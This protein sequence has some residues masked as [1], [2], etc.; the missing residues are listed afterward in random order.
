VQTSERSEA[1]EFTHARL[2]CDGYFFICLL[3]VQTSERSG[4][5]EFTHARLL[6]DGYFFI[7]L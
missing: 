5:G 6:C 1:G 4:A 3:T 2:L 7:C